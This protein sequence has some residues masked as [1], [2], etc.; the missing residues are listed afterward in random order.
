MKLKYVFIIMFIFVT[1]KVISL[2]F[3]QLY[4]PLISAIMTILAI[5]I[6]GKFNLFFEKQINSFVGLILCIAPILIDLM[7]LKF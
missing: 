5:K 3:P 7:F 6:I 2:I 4:T 1:T